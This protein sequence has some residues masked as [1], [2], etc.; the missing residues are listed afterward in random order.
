MHAYACACAVLRAYIRSENEIV[1]LTKSG[2]TK[3][4]GAILDVFATSNNGSINPIS[5]EHDVL[6][7][8]LDLHIFLINTPFHVYHKSLGASTQLH[9]RRHSLINGLILPRPVFS[10]HDVGFRGGCS[11]LGFK[12]LPVGRRNPRR[13]YPVA[14]Q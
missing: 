10:H 14:G 4:C 2:G 7:R 13:K 9:R 3:S 1:K 8:F 6:H 5:N 12:E 11:R